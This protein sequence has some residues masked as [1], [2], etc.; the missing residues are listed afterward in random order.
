VEAGRFRVRLSA[1]VRHTG[2]HVRPRGGVGA[3][4]RSEVGGGGAIRLRTAKMADLARDTPEVQDDCSK[5]LSV[6]P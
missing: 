4:G 1:V 5:A 3:G 2:A 6:S